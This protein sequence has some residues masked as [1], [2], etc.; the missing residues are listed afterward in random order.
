MISDSLVALIKQ[1]Q[2]AYSYDTIVDQ[3]EKK[4]ETKRSNLTRQLENASS[5]DEKIKNMDNLKKSREFGSEKGASNWLSTLPLDEHGFYLH[6]EA[7]RDALSLRYGW[8]PSNLP[9][10][11]VCGKEFSVD[12][13]LSCPRGGF[14]TLR[15]N[16]IRDI[17]AN[18][19]G[20]VCHNVS[21]EPGLQ[22]VTGERFHHRSAIT[23]DDARL[24]VKARGFWGVRQQD[25]FFD[26]RVFNPFASSNRLTSLTSTYRLH[27]REKRRKYEQRVREVENGSF[28]P[29]VFS[30]T[31]GMG[32]AAEITYKRLASQIASKRK[33]KY[34]LCL[35][36][37][38]CRIS[39]SLL[40][41]AI[42]CIRGSRIK[43][44]TNITDTIIDLKARSH[45]KST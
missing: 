1:Q 2:K 38:R 23:Q 18:L 34:S 32:R 17:T 45:L 8:R 41:S 26:V 15:H 35:N 16:E 6:K 3:A 13:A 22:H 7:F 19:M 43:Y 14:P 42:M 4:K 27:E 9:S 21:T 24:D 33:E 20:E 36:W 40:R 28:T 30:A 5:L 11:C 10:D 12:H 39:F 29:L 25:A 44:S 31:G 37:I